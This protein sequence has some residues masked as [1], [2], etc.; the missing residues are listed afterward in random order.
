MD[1]YLQQVQTSFAQF[2][3]CSLQEDEND[4]QLKKTFSMP[5]LSNEK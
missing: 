3:K 5:Y 2:L 1:H 4:V